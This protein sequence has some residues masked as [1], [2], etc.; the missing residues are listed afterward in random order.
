MPAPSPATRRIT[1]PESV[2]IQHIF[3]TEEIRTPFYPIRRRARVQA[4][5][6]IHLGAH[7]KTQ[8]LYNADLKGKGE[9]ECEPVPSASVWS[10][11]SSH[12][13]P[14]NDNQYQDLYTILEESEQLGKLRDPES[15]AILETENDNN[16]VLKKP[17]TG[18]EDASGTPVAGDDVNVWILFRGDGGTLPY[19]SLE[20][21]QLLDCAEPYLVLIL[22]SDASVDSGST[23]AIWEQKRTKHTAQYSSARPRVRILRR[24]SILGVQGNHSLDR[25]RGRSRREWATRYGCT[26]PDIGQRVAAVER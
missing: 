26:L 1:V 20:L 2:D 18:N 11:D 21:K 17:E 23:H 7:Y 19:C 10:K 14:S 15:C 12:L 22:P 16:Y 25:N 5:R 6:H 9:H 3:I 8:N 4:Q 13:D 24:R